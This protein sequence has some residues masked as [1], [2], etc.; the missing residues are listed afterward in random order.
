MESN[1]FLDILEVSLSEFLNYI[2]QKNGTSR[3]NIRALENLKN[4]FHKLSPRLNNKAI[5]NLIKNFEDGQGFIN[6]YEEILHKCDHLPMLDI[7][8]TGKELM[9]EL[10]FEKDLNPLEP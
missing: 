7:I 8:E 4:N 5:I 9:K 1:E 3:L 6:T 10:V 2:Q